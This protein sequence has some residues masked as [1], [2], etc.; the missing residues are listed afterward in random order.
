[1]QQENQRD[2]RIE[3]RSIMQQLEPQHISS[4]EDL[5]AKLKDALEK[6]Q[7]IAITLRPTYQKTLYGNGQKDTIEQHSWFLRIFSRIFFEI[8]VF[9]IFLRE[10]VRYPTRISR[11]KVDTETKMILVERW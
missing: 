11:F 9:G 5:I 6:A 1:M 7:G 2:A 10:V 4:W 8:K 3:A